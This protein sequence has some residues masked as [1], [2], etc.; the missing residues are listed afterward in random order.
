MSKNNNNKCPEF[1]CNCK[2]W[3]IHKESDF[4]E[5]GELSNGCCH[6]YPPYV[7]SVFIGDVY[8]SNQYGGSAHKIKDVVQFDNPLR[9]GLC[10]DHPTTFAFDRCGEFKKMKK[11]RYKWKEW[12][13]DGKPNL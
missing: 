7:P 5:K 1:C 6:R 10:V 11:P 4:K 12:L 13:K 9:G 8:V 2:H 3:E